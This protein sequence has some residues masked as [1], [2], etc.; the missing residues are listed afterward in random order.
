MKMLGTAERSSRLCISFLGT[1]KLPHSQC[2]KQQKRDL[3]QFWGESRED[4][5]GDRKS[6]IGVTGLQSRWW[7]VEPLPEA[8][9]KNVSSSSR[10]LPVALA[11]GCLVPIFKS[12]V[13]Q[14]LPAPSSHCLPLLVCQI[15]SCRL[16]TS[17]R[18]LNE[19]P[20]K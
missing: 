7:Q 16:L 10:W 8:P 6:E 15:F 3:L 19:G 18:Y 4:R 17:T 11:C 9:G 2:L 14:P 1:D 12:S 20:L 5:L 13:F